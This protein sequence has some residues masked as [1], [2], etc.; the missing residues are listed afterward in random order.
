MRIGTVRR[1]MWPLL[2]LLCVLNFSVNLAVIVA[3]EVPDIYD[4]MHLERVGRLLAQGMKGDTE[5]LELFFSATAG[6]DYPMLLH[7]AT[8]PVRL[9]TGD[10]PRAGAVG[11][12]LL[13]LLTILCTFG[14]A[15]IMGGDRVGLL[16]A[17]FVACAPGLYRF[18]R[19]TM[20]DAPLAAMVALAMLTLVYSDGLARRGWAVLVGLSAS[21]GML[22]KQSFPI[23]FALPAL[24][25]VSLGLATDK[26]PAR[27]KRLINLLI[28]GSIVVAV[29]VAYYLPGI[30]QWVES[31]ATVHA[32]YAEVDQVSTLDFLRLSAVESLG[33]PLTVLTLVGILLMPKRDRGYHVLLVWV[34]IPLIVLPSTI[35]L[36]TTRYLLPLLP[37]AAV[38]AAL[39]L[40]QATVW[41]KPV[42]GRWALVIAALTAVIGMAS[43]DHLR[44]DRG[45][46][47]FDDFEQRLHVVGI[48][49][50]QQLDYSVTPVVNALL[51][52][53]ADRR[54]VMLFD[55]PYSSMVQG[56]LWLRRPKA[57][58]T[59]LFENA[60]LGRTP[61]E[62]AE[63]SLL[64]T[65][66][67][68][69]DYL[70]VKT[71]FDRDPRLY[72]HPQNVEESF[73]RDV[74]AA[75]F[76]VKSRFALVDSFDYPEDEGPVLLYRRL[77]KVEPLGVV[78]IESGEPPATTTP[79]AK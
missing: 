42:W 18:S 25:L 44:P 58:I 23:Y 77:E 50:P 60:S 38:L 31:R 4:P 47:A 46:F 11:V 76:Q 33:W 67:S 27:R 1:W 10:Q 52:D 24:Y 29:T 7:Y 53:G 75:F 62:L 32:F 56:G 39:G 14:L 6:S 15:H 5:A 43:F 63:E 55:S 3:D 65:Y 70:L 59:N 61:Q 13:S 66:L 40:E 69:A 22:T 54:I 35:N 51:D 12:A 36:A 78:G 28:A 72:S 30:S 57:D 68:G 34:V 71:G 49:R 73:A 45:S 19:M 9:L 16:A 8:L 26:R 74:F 79:P 21:L 2:A 17:T 48:P 20:T 37:A 64:E 41:I